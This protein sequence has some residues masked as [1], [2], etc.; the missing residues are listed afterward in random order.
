[1]FDDLLK[2]GARATKA[3]VGNDLVKAATWIEPTGLLYIGTEIADDVI[4]GYVD[5]GPPTNRAQKTSTYR[6]RHRR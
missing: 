3:V 2:A 1:M 6:G 4:D 5:E